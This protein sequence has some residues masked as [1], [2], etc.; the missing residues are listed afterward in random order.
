MRSTTTSICRTPQGQILHH[1]VAA[2]GQQPGGPLG[3]HNQVRCSGMRQWHLP[4]HR[5][6]TA[7]K[8]LQGAHSNL[9][10]GAESANLHSLLERCSRTARGSALILLVSC[11][12]KQYPAQTLSCSSWKHGRCPIPL[13]GPIQAI[14]LL[15]RGIHLCK[16]RARV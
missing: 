3:T 5:A 4:L 14:G 1:G 13:N 6:A 16:Q 9:P 12:R 7:A 10:S 2:L 8:P 15:N 11:T